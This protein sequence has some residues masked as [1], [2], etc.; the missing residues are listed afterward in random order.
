MELL[1]IIMSKPLLSQQASTTI[2]SLLQ[3]ACLFPSGSRRVDVLIRPP[4]WFLPISLSHFLTT[5]QHAGLSSYRRGILLYESSGK[6]WYSQSASVCK[7]HERSV[8]GL[9]LYG[10]LRAVS[11]IEHSPSV[12]KVK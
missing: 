4:P 12:D 8:S 5:G 9:V 6:A 10:S 1:E 7:R 3:S 2:K 11:E